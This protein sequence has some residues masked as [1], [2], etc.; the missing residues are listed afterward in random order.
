L[1]A[2]NGQCGGPNYIGPSGCVK[3]TTC[4]P[5][6]WLCLSPGGTPQITAATKPTTRTQFNWDDN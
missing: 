3:G 1:V 5:L 6:Y 4:V 2:L